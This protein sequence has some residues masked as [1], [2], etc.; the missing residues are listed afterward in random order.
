MSGGT[1]ARARLTCRERRVQTVALL[2]LVA[3]RLM[4]KVVPFRWMVRTF[5]LQARRPELEGV[6][7]LRARNEV[8]RAVVAASKRV[9]GTA[10]IHR[11][12]TAQAMLRHRGVPTTLWCGA[13]A[14]GGRGL[15]AHV[16]LKD[17]HENVMGCRVAP[18]Y[19]ALAS[20]PAGTESWR[21]R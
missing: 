5:T 15:T 16:W 17:G 20:Y 19:V 18:D 8:R 11:A 1:G 10:C 13:S 9:A 12:V 3:A 21:G 7:R 2:Y 6:A 14:S 4:L